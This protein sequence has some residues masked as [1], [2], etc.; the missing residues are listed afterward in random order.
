MSKAQ[1]Y[2]NLGAAIVPLLAV[3]AAAILSW[4]HILHWRDVA[5]FAAMYL[6]AGFGVTIGFHRLLTHRSFAT[7]KPVAYS[8]AMAGSMS[9]QRPVIG[10]GV[11]PRKHPA[12]PH[13]DGA[14]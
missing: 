6:I 10:W 2:S 5:I 14:P 8:L 1:R 13:E 12:R 9:G 7:Y 4:N 11:G 3:I